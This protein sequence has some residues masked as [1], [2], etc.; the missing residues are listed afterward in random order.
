[1]QKMT[2][3]LLLFGFGALSSYG[4]TNHKELYREAFDE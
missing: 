3:L 1:M 2:I 4:Q